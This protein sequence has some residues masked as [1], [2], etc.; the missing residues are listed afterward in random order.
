MF[1]S[2]RK[3]GFTLIELLVVIAIIGILAGVILVFLSSARTKSR[4]ARVKASIAQVRN[5]AELLYSN[6][7]YPTGLLKT[8]L[9]FSPGKVPPNCA[10]FSEPG[11]PNSGFSDSRINNLD[12]DVRLQN[13]STCEAL[14]MGI[15]INNNG[16]AYAAFAQLPSTGLWCIDST[17][18]SKFISSSPGG[19]S[20]P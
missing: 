8:P 1:Y 4:D 3:K 15:N 17:G 16:S 10:Y 20:C 11:N 12:N 9:N 2:N 14:G 6:G 7:V 13:G 18:K 5:I 19:T